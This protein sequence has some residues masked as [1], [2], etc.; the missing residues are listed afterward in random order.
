MT[1]KTEQI[2]KRL[3]F[4]VHSKGITEDFHTLIHKMIDPIPFVNPITQTREVG[5]MQ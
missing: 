4:H 3:C 2:A 1:L 5:E